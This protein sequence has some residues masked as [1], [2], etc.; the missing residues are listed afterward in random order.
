MIFGMSV[1][2]GARRRAADAQAAQAFRCQRDLLTIAAHSPGIPAKLLTQANRHGILQM[3]APRFH[4]RIKFLRFRFQRPGELID[5]AQHLVQ[6]PQH[7]QANRRGDGV[8]GRLG[9]VN[10]VVGADHFR[11]AALA[12]QNLNRPI[13]DHFVGVHVM[14]GACACLKRIDTELIVP[15]PVDDL[16]RGLH[17]RRR[18]LGIE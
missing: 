15:L 18:D 11:V 8:V 1:E 3:R 6:A 17:N 16:L 4:D 14:T 2:A 13:G 5:R 9:H 12:T 10:M 7:A